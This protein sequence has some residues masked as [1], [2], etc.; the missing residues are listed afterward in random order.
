MSLDLPP[1]RVHSVRPASRPRSAGSMRRSTRPPP[2][3]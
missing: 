1:T 2:S 3:P